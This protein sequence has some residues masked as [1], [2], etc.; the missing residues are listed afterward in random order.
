MKILK[1]I[2]KSFLILILIVVCLFLYFDSDFHE[3]RRLHSQIEKNLE[4]QLSEIPDLIDREKYGW[5]E[6]GGD[7]ALLA[8]N[9]QDCKIISSAMTDSEK[10]YEESEYYDIFNRNNLNPNSLKTWRNSNAHGD[11]TSYALDESTCN[12]YRRYHYE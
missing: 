4:L 10:Y 7:K 6:E 1:I 11:Y 3:E 9:R 8:L 5:A 12:L 2:G